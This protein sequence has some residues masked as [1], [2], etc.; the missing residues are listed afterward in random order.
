MTQDIGYVLVVYRH[1][2]IETTLWVA[3]SSLIILFLLL[4]IISR[5]LG[6]TTQISKN[7]K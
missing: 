5:L 3:A 4:Y 7:L 2:S 1:W 6:R